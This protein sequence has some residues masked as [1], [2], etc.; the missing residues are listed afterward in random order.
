MFRSLHRNWRKRRSLSRILYF[1]SFL[2]F[3]L[4]FRSFSSFLVCDSF[5]GEHYCGMDFSLV[6]ISVD[7]DAFMFSW[8]SRDAFFFNQIREP[9]RRCSVDWNW[10]S[11][12]GMFL[13]F[14]CW[15]FIWFK[16]SGLQCSVFSNPR[17]LWCEAH[18]SVA[19]FQK[20]CS[21]IICSNL[22]SLKF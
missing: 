6:E 7:N 21:S 20:I 3:S 14:Q 1:W 22:V 8:S 9:Y 4:N 11:F 17:Q 15:I 5:C 2:S 18:Y 19:S 16:D 10:I 12:S 13:D